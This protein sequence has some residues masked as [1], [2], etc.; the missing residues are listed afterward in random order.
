MQL[1]SKASG[2]WSWLGWW[3]GSAEGA[4]D[5]SEDNDGVLDGRMKAEGAELSVGVAV[6]NRPGVKTML[7]PA[8][9]PAVPLDDLLPLL[10]FPDPP[11]APVDF[12]LR[13]RCS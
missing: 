4:P 2:S 3:L 12:D 10:P 13:R 1:S 6:G 7:F 9:V 8:A 5:G 11:V